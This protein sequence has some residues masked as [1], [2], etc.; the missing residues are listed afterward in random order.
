VL[1]KTLVPVLGFQSGLG[2]LVLDVKVLTKGGNLKLRFDK[3]NLVPKS[4]FFIA[5]KDSWFA[6]FFNVEKKSEKAVYAS[7]IILTKW[8]KSIDS[9]AKIHHDQINRTTDRSLLK[10]LVYG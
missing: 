6:L 7:L 10:C 2:V 1:C 5:M 9:F 3:A 8:G 4:W